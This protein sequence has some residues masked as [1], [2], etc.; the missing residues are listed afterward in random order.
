MYVPL[1]IYVNLSEQDLRLETWFL[2]TME[3]YLT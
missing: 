3:R 1:Y 2:D